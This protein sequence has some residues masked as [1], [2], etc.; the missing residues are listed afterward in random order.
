MTSMFLSESAPAVWVFVVSGVLMAAALIFGIVG[1][2]Y[3]MVQKRRATRPVEYYPPRGFSPVDLMA[4]YYGKRAKAHD[5]FNPMALY[6][7]ERGFVT[8]EEDCKRGL[9]LTKLKP[10]TMAKGQNPRSYSIEKKFFDNLFQRGDVFYTLAAKSDAKEEYG[11]FESSCEKLAANVCVKKSNVLGT[12][13]FIAA[14]LMLI[15]VTVTV[16]VAVGGG[17]AFVMLFPIIAVVALRLFTIKVRDEGAIGLVK[18]PFFAIWG[19]LPLMGAIFGTG[20]YGSVLAVATAVAMICAFLLSGAV[21]VRSKSDVEIYGRI[22]SFKR[23]LIEAEVDKLEMLVEEDP[24]YFYDILPYCYILKI[25]EKLKPK[26]D[27][28]N[29][30]GPSWYLGDM[31]DTLMF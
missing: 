20:V 18:W 3:G 23:F 5:L 6:W 9:K 26:F 10:L 14:V 24:E 13:I 4:K 2:A 22:D 25:T 8:I 11:R 27:R 21:D 15:A 17:I 30:D 31:R 12:A 29:L 1:V 16:G 19:G 7:A 28:M